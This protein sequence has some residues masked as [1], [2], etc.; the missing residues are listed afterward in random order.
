[1]RQ[2]RAFFQ[3]KLGELYSHRINGF[4]FALMQSFSGEDVYLVDIETL[5]VVGE[6]IPAAIYDPDLARAR[7]PAMYEAVQE[8]VANHAVVDIPIN[9]IVKVVAN[10]SFVDKMVE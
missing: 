1:M 10:D 3:R 4:T 7:L 6:T 8:L 9:N 5:Y 2:A